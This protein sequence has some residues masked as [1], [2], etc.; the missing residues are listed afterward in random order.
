MLLGNC[1]DVFE[2]YF[3]LDKAVYQPLSVTSNVIFE[4]YARVK[5]IIKSFIFQVCELTQA[6]PKNYEV[7]AHEYYCVILFKVQE[8]VARN[9][10]G[11]RS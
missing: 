6:Y 1:D 7:S 3:F 2:H 4:S 8:F 11:Q 9:I 5:A 10:S